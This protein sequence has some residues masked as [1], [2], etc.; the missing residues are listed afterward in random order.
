M[1]RVSLK[2]GVMANGNVAVAADVAVVEAVAIGRINTGEEAEAEAEVEALVATMAAMVWATAIM[3]MTTT[4]MA[5]MAMEDMAMVDMVVAEAVDE[6]VAVVAVVVVAAEE[7]A[8]E[9]V[10]AEDASVDEVVA[11][12][13]LAVAEDSAVFAAG[14]VSDM[15]IH[16]T[17]MITLS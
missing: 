16:T 11:A 15:M 10:V 12:D 9:E 2:A 1:P 13:S 3:A 5:T 6:A 17:D 4:A 8:S 14:T 7:D